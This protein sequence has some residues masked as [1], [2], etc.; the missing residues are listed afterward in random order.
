MDGVPLQ[1]DG[2]PRT[3]YEFVLCI[4][5][6]REL[7]FLGMAGLAARFSTEGKLIKH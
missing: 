3:T 5:L 6:G 7:E 1:M 2:G 4:G